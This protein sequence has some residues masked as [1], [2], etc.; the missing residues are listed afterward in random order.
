MLN[1]KLALGKLWYPSLELSSKQSVFQPYFQ[2]LG[3]SL[4]CWLLHSSRVIPKL[5]NLLLSI[6]W[7]FYVG[8]LQYWKII[9][10]WDHSWVSRVHP[11][12]W[13]DIWCVQCGYVRRALWCLF[14]SLLWH[15]RL[16]RRIKWYMRRW[17]DHAVGRC[18]RVWKSSQV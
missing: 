8:Y 1:F 15:E 16:D 18:N 5:H 4:C 9:L 11:R 7:R 13:C 2:L 17:L 6:C 10:G 3:N 12:C 14:T